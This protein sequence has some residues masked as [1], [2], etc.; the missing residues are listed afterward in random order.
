MAGVLLRNFGK[1]HNDIYDTPITKYITL[2]TQQ[3]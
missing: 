3:K 2:E 1:Q